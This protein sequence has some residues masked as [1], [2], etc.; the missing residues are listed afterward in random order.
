MNHRAKLK[1]KKN[2]NLDIRSEKA[3]EIRV[4]EGDSGIYNNWN[5]RNIC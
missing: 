1:V 4:Y 5:T 2:N 3:T